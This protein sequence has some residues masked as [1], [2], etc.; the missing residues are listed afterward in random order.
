MRLGLMVEGQ[1]NVTWEQ[2]V[3]LAAVCERHGIEALFRSDHYASVREGHVTASLDAWTT[4]AGLAVHTTHLR[5]GTLVSPVTFRHPS[6]TAKSVVTVDHISGGRVELGLGAGWLQSEHRMYGFAFPETAARMQA[7]G[8][9]AEI[10][11]RQWTE[12]RV[13]F[14]GRHYRMQDLRALPKPVQRPHPPLIL[15]GGAGRQS[16]RLAARWA[17][18][19][20]TF[21]ASPEACRRRREQ[22]AEACQE[23]GRDP[24]S[25]RF[26]L[27]MPCI[28]A[29]DRAELLERIQRLQEI[30]RRPGNPEEFLKARPDEYLVGTVDEVMERLYCYQQAGVERVLLGHLIHDDLE[31]VR[32]VGEELA[33]ALR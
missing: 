13:D 7:L 28:T 25:L 19:Y 11:H 9:Q 4:L 29:G 2:W 18:E 3:A 26:S 14:D 6:L 24:A 5:L 27:M 33:P 30:Q 8:E 12:E 16:A 23:I 22:V 1:E 17:D 20:N 31:M 32:L 10:I 21:D 15:G